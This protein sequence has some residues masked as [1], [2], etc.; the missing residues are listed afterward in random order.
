MANDDALTLLFNEAGYTYPGTPEA[1]VRLLLSE[2][3][4][5]GSSADADRKRYAALLADLNAAL[6]ASGL[7]GAPSD[8]VKH[9]ARLCALT[10]K[11]GSAALANAL[12]SLR[13][14][15]PSESEALADDAEFLY[16]LDE[17]TKVSRGTMMPV[18][19][20][21]VSY[22]QVL[23]DSS[24]DHAAVAAALARF[25]S[26]TSTYLDKDYA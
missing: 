13:A 21:S 6:G 1:G 26:A 10:E 20:A 25:L 2:L 16:A 12:R 9:V 11:D 19:A 14:L 17:L 23:Q 8:P 18:V 3:S 15:H 4:R 7:S 24:S 22:C 5:V